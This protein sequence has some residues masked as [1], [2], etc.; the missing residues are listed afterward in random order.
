MVC[1]LCLRKPCLQGCPNKDDDEDGFIICRGC[2]THLHIG[3]TVYFDYD[4]CEYCIDEH[5]TEITVETLTEE[6]D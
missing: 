1:D 3:D 4:I 5:A 2:G 6:E